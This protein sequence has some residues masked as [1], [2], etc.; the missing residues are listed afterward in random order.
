MNPIR[1]HWFSA[2]GLV[3]ALLVAGFLFTSCES[4]PEDVELIVTPT[5]VVVTSHT[6]IVFRASIAD[7]NRLVFLPFKWEVSN[8]D[9]G[10]IAGQ[11]AF[12]AVYVGRGDVH[13]DNLIT[14]SDQGESRGIASVAHRNVSEPVP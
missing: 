10:V 12:S 11:E 9:L 2:A 3:V 8:P 4:S 5:E 1:S 6:T 7:T 13:G 14:V